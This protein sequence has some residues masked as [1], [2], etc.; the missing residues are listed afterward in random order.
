VLEVTSK[1]AGFIV[2]GDEAMPISGGCAVCPRH[3]DALPRWELARPEQIEAWKG[4]QG[5][6]LT[7]GRHRTEGGP[8]PS[9]CEVCGLE[10]HPDQP[11]VIGPG[12]LTTVVCLPC[13][14]GLGMAAAGAL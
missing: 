8:G 14:G 5:F 10:I 13:I 7:Y 3:P 9:T 11:Y 6:T 12:P 2:E 1:P 4:R